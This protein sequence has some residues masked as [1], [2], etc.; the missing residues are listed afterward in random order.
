[1]ADLRKASVLVV[2]G[3]G[4]IDLA[5]VR[6]LGQAGARVTVGSPNGTGFARYSRY[7]HHILEFSSP[8]LREIASETI[9]FIQTGVVTHVIT[10]EESLIVHLNAQ[11]AEIEPFATLLFPGS[12]AFAE[13]LHKDRTLARAAHLGIPAPRTY[14]PPTLDDLHPCRDWTYP[15]VFKPNHRDPRL[16]HPSARDYIASYA[17]TYDDLCAQ[18]AQLGPYA[19]P[20]MIQEFAVGEGV[21]VEVLMRD[22]EP[23]LLFQ[24]RRL[25]EKPATGGISVLCESEK[26]SPQLA[27]H[28]V[29]LLRDMRWDGVAMVEFRQDPATGEAKLLEVN[30]RFW[31]SLPLALHAGADFPAE[32]LRTQLDRDY[33]PAQTYRVG[34]RCRSL[35][36]DTSSLFETL[37]TGNRSRARAL[38]N[39]LV[40][41]SPAVGGYVWNLR[42]PWPALRHPWQRLFRR[43]RPGVAVADRTREVKS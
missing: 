26:L 6:S 25:R 41:F 38:W 19:D 37:R 2:H 31:G 21:G 27:D 39:Y 35:A 13:C 22:G 1:M 28:A 9:A 42:D 15:V 7:A 17:Q 11:R 20:P 16:R 5:M 12:E 18:V 30:G 40:A 8:D 43:V 14:V 4:H 33:R 32:L 3:G 34:A 24:H 36:H 10:A 23:R 29:R